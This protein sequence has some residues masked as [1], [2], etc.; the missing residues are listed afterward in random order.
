MDFD[1]KVFLIIVEFIDRGF[2][3]R[4]EVVRLLIKQVVDGGIIYYIFGMRFFVDNVF[5]YGIID[6]DLVK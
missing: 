3:E 6:E 4:E 2:L 5:K 1:S